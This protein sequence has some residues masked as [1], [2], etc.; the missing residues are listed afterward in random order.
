MYRTLQYM[1]YF[2][3]HNS[4]VAYNP[5]TTSSSS[6]RSLSLSVPF[7]CFLRTLTCREDLGPYS[8]A[9]VRTVRDWRQT[10]VTAISNALRPYAVLC[11]YAIRPCQIGFLL[12]V[13]VRVGLR[14]LNP[15]KKQNKFVDGIFLNNF[16]VPGWRKKCNYTIIKTINIYVIPSTYLYEY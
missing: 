2:L 1:S 9:T 4:R 6:L 13:R 10:A 16:E 8:C 14:V 7:S 11:K 15:I 12:S 3:A 5:R